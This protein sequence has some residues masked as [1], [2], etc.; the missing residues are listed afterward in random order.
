MAVSEQIDDPVDGLVSARWYAASSL[1][2]G[3]FWG[4]GR[5][6]KR[7]LAER[8]TPF[9]EEQKSTQPDPFGLGVKTIV[10]RSGPRCSQEPLPLSALRRS[11]RRLILGGRLCP[12]RSKV[13]MTAWWICL[14]VQPPT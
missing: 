14:A 8:R 2:A 13:V 11:Y 4:S 3:W 10:K 5:W 9:V 1:L 7:L 6:W 12:E